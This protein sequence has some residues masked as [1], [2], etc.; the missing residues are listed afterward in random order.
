[1][2]YKSLG[3]TGLK[4]SAVG[5]G[6]G[7][8]GGVGSAPAF[9]EKGESKEEAFALMDKAWDIGIRLFDTADAYGGGRS[10]AYIGEWLRSKGSHVRDQLVLSSKLFNPVGDGPNQRGLSRKHIRRQIESTLSR[11]GIEQLDMYLIHEP[12]PATPLS[13]T[14]WTLDDLI[15]QGK[16]NYIGASNMPAWLTV[17]ALWESDRMGLQRFEWVQ[18]SYSLLDRSDEAELLPLCRDQGLGYT[19][20]SPLSGGFLTGKY[21]RE[22]E[23]PEGSRMTLRPEPYLHLWNENTFSALA[24]LQDEADA[25]GVSMAGLALAWV[26]SHPL[27]TAPIVGPRRPEHLQPVLEALAL[28]LDPEERTALAQLFSNV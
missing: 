26:M 19:P 7:N 27:V 22:S 1:M 16:I 13:E 12:D 14:L 2:I 9:F 24:Q 11:L 15:R 6:C 10:E 23:Y 25:R 18:N 28:D 17:K 4:I 20:F 21:R 8:F 3:R 5:L